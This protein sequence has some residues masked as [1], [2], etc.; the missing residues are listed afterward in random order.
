MDDL[1]S[2]R[3][4]MGYVRL[5]L[6]L[7]NDWVGMWMGHVVQRQVLARIWQKLGGSVE[8]DSGGVF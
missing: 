2:A 5:M 6:G 7:V 8:V 3:V 1:Q 4:V